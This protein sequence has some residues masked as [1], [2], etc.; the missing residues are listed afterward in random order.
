LRKQFKEMGGWKE[1]SGWERFFNFSKM[2]KKNV[3]FSKVKN[4]LTEKIFPYHIKILSSQIK[5]F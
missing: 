3:Q 1:I 4:G 5:P 2:D